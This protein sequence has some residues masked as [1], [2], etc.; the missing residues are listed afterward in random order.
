M[1]TGVLARRDEVAGIPTY[2]L[3]PRFPSD[4]L[5][6]QWTLGER[7]P[8]R[9]LRGQAPADNVNARPSV[10][11]STRAMNSSTATGAGFC[12]SPAPRVF[13]AT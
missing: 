1:T 8:P 3:L 2:V 9:Q 4:V 11:A 5:V 10:S 6:P 7:Q 13:T 12:P